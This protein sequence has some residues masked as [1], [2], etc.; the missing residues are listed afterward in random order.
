[1]IY[2]L[3]YIAMAAPAYI[4]YYLIIFLGFHFFFYMPINMKRILQSQVCVPANFE[5][6][7]ISAIFWT[8][9]ATIVNP[10]LL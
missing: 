8:V 7:L 10:K 1:M 3:I 9:S 4:S 5:I 6:I 2:Y